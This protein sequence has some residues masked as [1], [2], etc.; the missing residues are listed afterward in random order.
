ME[1]WVQGVEVKNIHDLK[2]SIVQSNMD[3]GKEVKKCRQSRVDGKKC[4][5]SSVTLTEEGLV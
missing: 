5:E 1:V 4:Q 2:V 3:C